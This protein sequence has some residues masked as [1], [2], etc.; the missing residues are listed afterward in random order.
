V[1]I[2]G[3]GPAVRRLSGARRGWHGPALILSAAIWLLVIHAV[4]LASAPPVVRHLRL[5]VAGWLADAPPV[6]IALLSDLHVETPTDSP[7]HLASVVAIANAERPDLV[8]IAGD[9]LSTETSLVHPASVEDTVAPLA[10]LH[11]PLGTVAVLGNHDYG[12]RK[13]LESWLPRVGVTLLQNEA[14]RRGPLTMLGVGDIMT[15]H[16]KP[17]RTF[18]RSRP[19][20]GLPIVLSHSPDVTPEL[21]T[22]LRLVLAGHTHCGQISPWPIGPIM[23]ASR[24]GRRYACGLIR[25]GDRIILVTAGLGTSNLPLRLGAAPDL[26]VIDLGP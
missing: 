1:T 12:G 7:R 14:I 6:R 24:Y 10:R 15:G 5:H 18:A 16:A 11:A 17:R 19:L 13:A 21:D 20:G 2:D 3:A 8:A 25:E 26:W 23:T 22:S 4:L 9:F